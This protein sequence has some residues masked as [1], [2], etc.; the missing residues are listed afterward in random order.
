[1]PLR[2]QKLK[3][4]AAKPEPKKDKKLL[5]SLAVIFVI[6]TVI[7]VVLDNYG[8]N[9]VSEGQQE[10]EKILS[11]YRG[12]LTPA[13]TINLSQPFM[14][15]IGTISTNYTADELTNGV[16]LTNF[17]HIEVHQ[18]IVS[19]PVRF[20][21]EGNIIHIYAEIKDENNETIGRVTD[22]DW[23]AATPQNTPSVW[24]RNYNAYAFELIDGN[25]IPVLQI[26]MGQQNRI[27][28]GFSLFSQGLSCYFGI[29]MGA[30]F[31]QIS[32]EDLQQI[33]SSTLFVYPSSDHIGELKDSTGYPTN[34]VLAGV[35]GK[36]QIGN[37]LVITGKILSVLFG[38]SVA[39]LLLD[40]LRK[41]GK[42]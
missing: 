38:I 11:A 6:L 25:K 8:N 19:F 30:F 13:Y 26:S 16:D 22:N 36:I 9:L 10:K 2:K 20:A 7:G 35:N 17:I 40:V 1:M 5:I 33:R 14:V 3:V 4:R 12:T 31:G 41:R 42:E 27:D 21:F 23:W 34:N 39:G 29:T 28:I 32:D 24:D 18:K 15:S 37:N